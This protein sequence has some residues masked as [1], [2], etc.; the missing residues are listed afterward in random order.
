MST[1]PLVQHLR[2]H[3][4]LASLARAVVAVSGEPDSLALL[5]ALL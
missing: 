4:T 2:R 3:P 1:H 5:Y